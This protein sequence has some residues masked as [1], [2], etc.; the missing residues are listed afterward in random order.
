VTS[1][2][3][4]RLIFWLAVPLMLLALCSALVHYF[5]S[6]APGVIDSDRRLRAAANALMAHV[7]VTG[8][9]VTLEADSEGK[10]SLPAPDSI[11][12][13]LRDS[14]GRLLAGD[15]R[16]PAV[17]MS[18]ETSQQIAMTQLDHRTVRSLTTRFDTSGGVIL[19]T[20]ADIRPAAEP[21]ARYGFMSTLLWDFVLLDMTLVLVWVGIQLGLR[22]V[23][24]L[25]DEIAARSPQ[26]LRPIGESSVPREIAPVVVTLN[27]LFTM[28]RSSVQSQQQFIANTAHQLRT[29]ITGLQAQL[30][31]LVA[32]SA[33]APVRS[34]LL[35]LQ[36]GIRQ[37]AH[38]ANQLLTLARA[39]PAVNITTKNQTVALDALAGDIVAKFFDRALK[40]NIDLGVEVEPASILADPSLIDDLLSNLVDNALKY[41]PAGG[42]VTVSTDQKNGRAY[43]AVEDTGPGI[44]E[45]DRHRVLQRFYRLPNSPGH[46]S[47]L[48]LAIV[49][50]IAQLYDASVSIGSGTDGRGTRIQVQFPRAVGARG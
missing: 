17:P 48:G 29:P 47:G 42:S 18:R 38:S 5:N 28:L 23:K 10:P 7:L 16:L 39:D 3:S 34:R 46:G 1:S 43:L 14:Q 49:D 21:A 40:S 27:R 13:A 19:I 22:P 50:E 41:T 20:A 35:T 44:P 9:Q 31:L 33:A 15:A 36:E 4:R 2:I 32:E 26:D 12:Y 6:I 25:R 11:M 45:S 37:L 8:G 24:K 30:E